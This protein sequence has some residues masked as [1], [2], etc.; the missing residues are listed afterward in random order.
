MSILISRSTRFQDH[1]PGPYHPES[2][3]RLAAIDEAFAQAQTD[4]LS[5]EDLAP[6]PISNEDIL[7]VHKQ[8]HIER[9]NEVSGQ[10]THLDSDTAVSSASVDVAR[11]AA[12]ATLSVFETVALRTGTAGLSLVRPPGHHAIAER[13]MGFC[14]LGNMAIAAKSLLDRQIVERIAIY[15]WDVH[16]G[17]GTQA[18]FID[19]PRVLFMS[20]H[21]WPFYPGTGAASETGIGDAEGS[22]VNIPLPEGTADDE[23]LS[24][25][26]NVLAPRVKSFSPDLILISAGFDGHTNDPLGGFRLT[27]SGYKQL[28]CRWRDIAESTCQGRIAGVLEGGYNFDALAQ[29]VLATAKAWA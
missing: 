18:M 21:Q 25:T 28:A 29:S 19:D 8:S 20:T 14:L 10:S 4:G 9:L 7:R 13:A 1:N 12:G 5:L 24:I 27:T 26:E 17:N 3:E 2:P 16:H 15:D 22:T 6:Q 11:L 23:I